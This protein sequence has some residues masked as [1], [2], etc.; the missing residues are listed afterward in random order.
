MKIHIRN[1]FLRNFLSVGND[2]INVEYEE[3][4]YRVKGKNL[5]T[6]DTNGVGKSTVYTDGLMYAL[7]GRTV[8]S[9]NKGDIS[10]TINDKKGCETIVEFDINGAEYKIERGIKPD[11]LELQK[12]GEPVLQKCSVKLVQE[13]INKILGADFNTF[14]HLL[15]MSKSYTKPFLDMSGPEKRVVIED[16]LGVSIFG[17]MRDYIRKDVE[18]ELNSVFKMKKREYESSLDTLQELRTKEKKIQEQIDNMKREREEKIEKLT[19]KKDKVEEI[20][21]GLRDAIINT[22]KMQDKVK[23]LVET[24]EEFTERKN[25]MKSEN[26]TME[27]EISSLSSK[28]AKLEDSPVCPLCNTETTSDHIEEHLTHMKETIASNADKIASNK[29]EVSKLMKKIKMFSER[30]TEL[31]GKILASKEA[32]GKISMYE[33]RSVELGEQ[34]EEIQ[35]KEED[36]DVFS[37]TEGIEKKEKEVSDLEAEINK[38]SDEKDY[39]AFIKKILS[40]DGIKN[41]IIQ[42]ILPF[43]NT[44]VNTYL[45]EVNADFT[46][47]FDNQLDAIIKSRGCDPLTYHS[48]SGGEKARID[49]SILMSIL[50]LSS[51][52]SSLDLNITILDELL[53]GSGLST[54][55]K[56]DVLRLLKLK[57]ETEKK[58]IYVISHHDSLSHDLFTEDIELIK[59]EGFTYL[60]E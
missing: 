38:M 17:K 11:K 27:K 59:K 45:K 41:Y 7:F 26:M 51:L 37:D 16:I 1:L 19:T 2:G 3:G 55:G 8:R 57:A 22:D 5:D 20:L 33:E 50:D 54:N 31:E 47:E 15:V 29:K 23:K 13:E 30:K 34:I 53:D 43:W 44:K 25:E 42:S 24:K 60:V 10:N 12:N 56:E 32:E 18:K 14:I 40:E 39:Y 36:Y 58:S 28:L 6:N 48:F 46:I 49:F 52:R 4:L 9:I 35:N 21:G